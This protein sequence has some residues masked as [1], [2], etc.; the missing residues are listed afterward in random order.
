[1]PSVWTIRAEETGALRGG[2]WRA[3][4]MT[5]T[6]YETTRPP[7]SPSWHAAFTPDGAE[8]L[9]A[10]G[11]GRRLSHLDLLSAVDYRRGEQRRG[12]VDLATALRVRADLLAEHL[13][14]VAR[15]RAVYEVSR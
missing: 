10:Y 8:R 9:T 13:R 1:V 12:E 2:P 11:V 7:F 6:R 5:A 14:D 3:A 15:L 4:T